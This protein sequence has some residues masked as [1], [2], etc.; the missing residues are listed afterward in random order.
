LIVA[1]A[2][3]PVSL[4]P[5]YL[6]GA[7]G[8]A[9]GELGYSYL[10]NYDS[11]G[12][13]VADVAAV[14]PTLGNG[15]I[16]ADGKRVTYHLRHDAVWQDGV[17]LSSRDVAFTYRAI[18]NP[19]N[20]VSSRYGYDRVASVDVPDPYTAV[21]R[22]K[23]SYAP[24]VSSFFGGDSNY[25]ILPAHLLAG[26]PNL[27]HVPYNAAP[28]G[29]GPY[30][31]A[32][33]TRGDRLDVIANEK[34]YA[35][36]PAISRLSLHFV[37]DSSTI[38]DQLATGEVDAAFFADVSQIAALRRIPKHRIVVTPVPYFYA[39]PFNV[40]DPL[41]KDVAI[42]RAF[43]FAIDRRALVRKVTHGLYD[44]ESGMRGLF[45]WAFDPRAGSVPYDP[46][47]AQAVLRNAGWNA[48]PDGIRTKDGRRLTLQLAFFTG[49]DIANE[50]V[51]LI[52]EQERA[53]GIDVTTKRYSREEFTALDG[54]LMQGRFQVALYAYQSTVDPD[55]S[56]L[57]ACGQRGPHGFNDARYCNPA[58]DRALAHAAS[59]LNRNA[60]RR[61]YR[62]VQRRLLADMPY[63]FLCQ[64]SEIDVI[65]QRLRGYDRPLLSPYASVA[66]WRYAWSR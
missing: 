62:F 57:L 51:P 17:P 29:S 54:P 6:E 34:Y 14:V 8:Y 39:L 10:T 63:E 30:R 37:H 22:L 7:L 65:P 25:P 40:T 24:I 43:A 41:T 46:R 13:I 61:D 38:A 20:S 60:R 21:V 50:F 45:T 32:R 33:W 64:V 56:W 26:Y 23:R 12:A 27:N 19:A 31:L 18:M 11:H 5:L 55:A 42:R 36:R 59:V 44:S 15:G 16:S 66:R 58:V 53:V 47:R 9:I 1:I 3:E 48:G 4:N 52:V 2:Q 35:G 49:S 28:I